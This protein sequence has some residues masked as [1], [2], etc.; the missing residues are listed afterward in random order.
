MA[1]ALHSVWLCYLRI[2]CQASLFSD[3]PY[4]TLRIRRVDPVDY[5]LSIIL[6]CYKGE[7]FIED[8]INV[9]QEEVSCFEKAF[10]LI[11]V[12]DGLVDDGYEKGKALEEI[13]KNLKVIGYE[14]NRGKGYAIQYGLKQCQ[15]DY[16]VFLD[17]DLDYHPKALRWFLKIM[18]E[19][20][21]D[22]VIGNR[23]YRNS[24]CRYPFLR[25]MAS[26]G[27]NLFI[28]FIFPELNVHDSQAGIK[29]IK[30]EAARNVFKYLENQKEAESF[31]FDICLLLAARKY[32]LKVIQAPCVFEMKSSTIGVGKN[33]LKLAFRMGMDVWRLKQNIKK[34]DGD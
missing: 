11:V 9:L 15:G 7:R 13:Y 17:S 19:E 22:L 34:R 27:F 18:K 33:F 28:S 4:T 24:I 25:K 2:R 14:R 1:D 31:N 26:R 20:D 29:M 10:E 3:R 32:D 30:R 16:I 6:P 23:R 8:S 12:I 5:S 21:A